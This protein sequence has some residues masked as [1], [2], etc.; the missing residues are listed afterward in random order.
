MQH[1]TLLGRDSWMRLN[2]RFYRTLAPRPG[3]DRVLGELTLLPPG[4]HGVTAFVP[5]S[6]THPERFNQPYT[7]DAGITLSHDHRLVDADLARS[8]G[9]PPLAGCCLVDMLHTADNKGEHV[10]EN[11]HQLIPLAS[12]ADVEPG[13]LICNPIAHCY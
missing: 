2:G 1:D 8:S 13:A 5:D 11:D 6:P 10:V 3:N 12:I 4:L 9:A 7:D